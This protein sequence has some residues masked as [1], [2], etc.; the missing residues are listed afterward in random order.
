MAGEF[1][2]LSGRHAIG[3]DT[4]VM[5]GVYYAD[6]GT[7]NVVDFEEAPQGY[8][9][10][11]EVL[12]GL[13]TEEVL[14]SPLAIGHAVDKAVRGAIKFNPL[15]TVMILRSEAERRGVARLDH[16]H[17][18]GLST[19]MEVGKV[20][21]GICHHQA[22]LACTMVSLLQ[23]RRDIG[24]EVSFEAPEPL[25]PVVRHAWMRFTRDDEKV[26][27]DISENRV[28]AFRQTLPPGLDHYLRP[29]E[30]ETRPVC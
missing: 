20:G 9:A 5:G 12:D 14:E 11:Y 2:Q 25:E 10:T 30:R 15:I 18:I 16:S 21:A 4:E 27:T 23:E 17:A 7:A 22:L 3:P 1:L 24:G 19:F 8:E 26:I 29:E 13:L 28:I 6:D